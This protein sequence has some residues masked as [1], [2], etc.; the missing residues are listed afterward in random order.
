M[1]KVYRATQ[2]SSGT[3]V[4]IKSLLKSRQADN[5]AV[6]KFLQEAQILS[7]LNHPNI[8]GVQGVGRFPGGGYFIVMEYVDGVDLQSQIAHA[9]L[10]TNEAVRVVRIVAKAIAYAHSHRVD[11]GDLKPANILL[12][13]ANRAVVTDFGLAQFIDAASDTPPWLVG[14][15]MGYISPEVRVHGC[16]PG[17]AADIYALGALLVALV[18]GFAPNGSDPFL[19]SELLTPIL[20]AVCAKCLATDPTDRFQSANRLVEELDRLPC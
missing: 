12:E 9:P 7:Q 14:G 2:R 3:Q 13:N 11:H 20:S 1:G 8:V 17:Q 10:P 15:T 19:G 16:L 4:A 6:E 18:T 5:H